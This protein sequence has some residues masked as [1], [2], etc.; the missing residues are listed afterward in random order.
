MMDRALHSHRLWPFALAIAAVVA[1]AGL[2]G[3]ASVADFAPGAFVDPAKY[4]LYD[5]MQ[6]GAER[7]SLAVQMADQQKLIDKANTG[8][9]GPVVGEIAYRNTYNSLEASSKLAD[10]VWHRNKCTDA[11]A[12]TP[13]RPPPPTPPNISPGN[14]R[15]PGRSG[16]AVR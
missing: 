2:G 7:R 13:S 1:G 16:G 14:A 3:C 12:A 8:V 11:S 4:D 10:E 6:L 15:P 9:A 5:C